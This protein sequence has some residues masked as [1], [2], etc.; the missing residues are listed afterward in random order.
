MAKTVVIRITNESAPGSPSPDGKD[1]TK[2][3]EPKPKKDDE[4]KESNYLK[5]VKAFSKPFT[6]MIKQAAET[7]FNRYIDMS[8]DYKAQIGV[9]NGKA[10][11]GVATSIFD[12]SKSMA[13]QGLALAGPAGSLIGGMLGLLH[14]AIKV[15]MQAGKTLAE[16]NRT[17]QEQ[18]YS[19]YFTTARAGMVNYSRGTEN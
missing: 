1:N 13:N 4:E 2:K 8:E 14:G 9:Q 11:I 3:K 12:S 19:L 18:A 16:Q 5:T 7:G 10:I 6:A 17:L 15:S